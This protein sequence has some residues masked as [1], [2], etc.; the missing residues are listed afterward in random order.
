MFIA[1]YGSVLPLAF[2]STYM[3]VY[4]TNVISKANLLKKAALLFCIAALHQRIQLHLTVPSVALKDFV[5]FLK[6]AFFRLGTYLI[7]NQ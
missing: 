3:K 7:Q 4:L 2:C 6:W 1:N 5:D